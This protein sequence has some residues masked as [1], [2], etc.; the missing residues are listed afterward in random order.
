M[1][2]LRRSS[3]AY[4]QRRM[5]D[6]RVRVCQYPPPHSRALAAFKPAPSRHSDMM[7][8]VRV[9]TV[10]DFDTVLQVSRFMMSSVPKI[11]PPIDLAAQLPRPQAS[12]L[13]ASPRLSAYMEEP[14]LRRIQCASAI[15]TVNLSALTVR[16][17]LWKQTRATFRRYSITSC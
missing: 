5:R 4:A 8:P 2:L 1:R 10:S 14:D 15:F 17:P 6:A 3:S 12:I 11:Q 16:E 7:L 9:C 13:K